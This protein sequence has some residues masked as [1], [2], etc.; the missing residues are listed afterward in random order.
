MCSRRVV[1]YLCSRHL[2][3]ERE[4][5]TS[6]LSGTRGLCDESGPEPRTGVGEEVGR[7]ALTAPREGTVHSRRSGAGNGGRLV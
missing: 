1:G 3:A 5:Q 4:F 6:V 2:K 7:L